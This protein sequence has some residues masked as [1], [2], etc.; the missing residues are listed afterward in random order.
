MTALVWVGVALLGGGASLLRF[1]VDQLVQ[2]RL[3]Y[4]FPWGTL[5]VNVTGSF[6]LGLLVGLGVAGNALLLLGTGAVG[7]YTTFST[8][9]LETER[10]AED[11]RS[12]AAAA[13]LAG[14]LAAGLAAVAAGWA[15]GAL[16]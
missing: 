5:L 16:H 9:M 6:V 12:G 15:L 10:L 14:S 8:W 4:P 11:G 2:H 13:N 7:S 1:R 3:G